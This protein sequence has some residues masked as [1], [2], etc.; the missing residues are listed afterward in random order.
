M[1][2]NKFRELGYNYGNGIGVEKDEKKSFEY[3]MKA[4]ELGDAV[5]I[6]HVGYCYNDG[7]GVEKD[8]KKCFEYYTKAA[9][10]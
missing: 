5:A 6:T 1:D 9:E 10:L 4:A 7:I 8:E 2:S 3:Y